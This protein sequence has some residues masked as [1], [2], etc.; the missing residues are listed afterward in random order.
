MKNQELFRK[1]G[2]KSGKIKV[3]QRVAFLAVVVL[4]AITASF[5]QLFGDRPSMQQNRPQ[6]FAA[7]G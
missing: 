5:A 1:F 7:V 4:M 3:A 2:A 6:A